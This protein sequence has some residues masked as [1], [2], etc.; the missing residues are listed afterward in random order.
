MPPRLGPRQAEILA[1]VTAHPGGTEPEIARATGAACAWKPLATLEHY[2]LV[3]ATV[4]DSPQHARTGGTVRRWHP[5]PPGTPPRPGLVPRT[6]RRP[7]RAESREAGRAR[8]EKA[9][10]RARGP[11]LA[12]LEER[13]GLTTTEI[14]AALGLPHRPN[15]VLFGLLDEGKLVRK[16][17][18]RTAGGRPVQP[19][20]I[21]P[22]GT[23]PPEPSAVTLA[24]QAASRRRH[25]RE[26]AAASAGGP[27][28]GLRGAACVGAAPEIFFPGPYDKA[29]PGARWAQEARQVCAGCE[30]RARCLEGAIERGE[31]FG[32]WGGQVFDMGRPAV[33]AAS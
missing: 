2:G 9:R 25:D 26:K 6:S 3:T 4:H 7:T 5:A 23:P 13:P 21:A 17:S 1:H 11:V 28:A 18:G 27:V 14:T 24:R 8:R 12:L 20:F 22:P 32:V 30:V 10:E 19:W 16:D 31:P 29:E 33:A 15:T